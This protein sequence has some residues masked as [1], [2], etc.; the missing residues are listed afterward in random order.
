[1]NIDEPCLQTIT[2]TNQYGSCTLSLYDR[3]GTSSYEVIEH[4]YSPLLRGFGYSDTVINQ[5]LEIVP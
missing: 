5:L 1:M 3:P 4:L 2:I